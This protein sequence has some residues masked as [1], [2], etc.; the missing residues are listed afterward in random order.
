MVLTMRSLSILLT[1]YP[2]LSWHPLEYQCSDLDS[3]RSVACC[4][5]P[6]QFEGQVTPII[7]AVKQS[8]CDF[9]DC[10]MLLQPEPPLTPTCYTSS[11]TV[12]GRRQPRIFKLKQQLLSW[13][14]ERRTIQYAANQNLLSVNHDDPLPSARMLSSIRSAYQAIPHSSQTLPCSKTHPQN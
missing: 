11:L 13:P 3:V 1:S 6:R 4:R 8:E 7:I 14:A 9:T 2:W 12:W 5:S 10:A